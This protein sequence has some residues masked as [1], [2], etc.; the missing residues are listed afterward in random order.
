L[1]FPGDSATSYPSPVVPGDVAP[2]GFGAFWVS[3][4]LNG[5]A[6][7]V[8]FASL[9]IELSPRQHVQMPWPTYMSHGCLASESAAGPIPQP[10]PSIP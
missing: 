3:T 2:G 5:C 1:I 7:G 8:R 10:T 6:D 4:Q 9:V